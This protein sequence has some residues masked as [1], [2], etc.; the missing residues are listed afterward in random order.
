MTGISRNN[1]RDLERMVDVITVL[2]VGMT[3]LW[4]VLVVLTMAYT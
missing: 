3:C 1:D 4:M 2:A